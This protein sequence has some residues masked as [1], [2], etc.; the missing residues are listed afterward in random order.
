MERFLG[1][2]LLSE[3]L[4]IV[5]SSEAKDSPQR[6]DS[7]VQNQALKLQDFSVQIAERDFFFYF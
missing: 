7:P 1:L 5:Q 4:N 6:S 3:T 2:F